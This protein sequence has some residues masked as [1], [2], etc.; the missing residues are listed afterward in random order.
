[1]AVPPRQ[2]PPATAAGAWWCCLIV[3]AMIPGVVS[4][5]AG[6]FMM[7]VG[8]AQRNQPG[9]H[10]RVNGTRAMN[11]GLTY[12]I[13]TIILAIAHITLLVAI[14]DGDPIKQNFLPLGIPLLLWLVHSAVF[15]I[16][17][18]V[19][20]VGAQQGKRVGINGIPFFRA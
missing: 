4:L 8:A 7:A 16:L 13:S 15:V 11:W 1:M 17:G 6:G 10:A 18:I 12:L 2:A 5:A 20:A 19:G 14:P 3:L 9:P